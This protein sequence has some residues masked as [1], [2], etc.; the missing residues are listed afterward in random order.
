MTVKVGGWQHA[1]EVFLQG[2]RGVGITII[3]VF[4]NKNK[5]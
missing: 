1:I 3:G 5:T 2:P 4:K